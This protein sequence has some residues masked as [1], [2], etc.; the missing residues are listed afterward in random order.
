MIL[1]VWWLVFGLF[2]SA[3][4]HLT[5]YMWGR[6][7]GF[8]S[9]VAMNSRWAEG[10]TRW[11]DREEEYHKKYNADTAILLEDNQ[12]LGVTIQDLC[13]QKKLITEE[14]KSLRNILKDIRGT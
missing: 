14:L 5:I 4:T 13:R 12:Q 9:S 7:H 2:V 11:V 6:G 1:S 8:A 3:V 10:S